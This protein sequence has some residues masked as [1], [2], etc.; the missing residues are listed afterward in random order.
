M[1]T[2]KKKKK[3]VNPGDAIENTAFGRWFENVK[4]RREAALHVFAKQ[5]PRIDS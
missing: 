4:G 5:I 1:F 2:Q 3:T